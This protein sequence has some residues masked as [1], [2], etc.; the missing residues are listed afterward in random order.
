M[1]NHFLQITSYLKYFIILNIFINKITFI[2]YNIL[3]YRYEYFFKIIFFINLI[4]NVI[5]KFIFSYIKISFRFFFIIYLFK[6]NKTYLS[7]VR[8][9]L[10]L[11]N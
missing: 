6:Y 3:S 2:I 7:N 4:H 11:K 9:N 5:I 1:Q 10:N 8:F